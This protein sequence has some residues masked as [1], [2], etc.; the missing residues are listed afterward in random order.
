MDKLIKDHLG[1]KETLDLNIMLS[2]LTHTTDVK[3]T[4]TN[5][6]HVNTALT[7]S[8]QIFLDD[9]SYWRDHTIFMKSC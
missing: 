8:D 7:R 5:G 4:Y 2:H 9:T 1:Y 6:F 3:P